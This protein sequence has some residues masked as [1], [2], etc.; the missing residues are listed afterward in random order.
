MNKIVISL[1]GVFNDTVHN[2]YT[3]P[4]VTLIPAPSLVRP[5]LILFY[6]ILTP[7][8]EQTSQDFPLTSITMLDINDFVAD[9]GGDLNKIRESQRRRYAP[10]SVIEEVLELFEAARRGMQDFHCEC[11]WRSIW[12]T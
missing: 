9:R 1:I 10:E 3:H 11:I 5:F 6:T 8:T 12:L 4:P 7:P 2:T